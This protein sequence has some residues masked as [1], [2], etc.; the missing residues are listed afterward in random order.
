MKVTVDGSGRDGIFALDIDADDGM[1]AAA[2][3]T[4]AQL[5]TMTTI[6][7]ATIS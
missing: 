1:V 2:S 5:T 6:T 4:T 7:T 3:T